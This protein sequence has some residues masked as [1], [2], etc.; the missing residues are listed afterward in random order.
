MS[1]ILIKLKDNSTRFFLTTMSGYSIFRNEWTEVNDNDKEIQRIITYRNDIELKD[2]KMKEDDSKSDEIEN[3]DEI[4]EIVEEDD[5]EE[6]LSLEEFINSEIKKAEEEKGKPLTKKQ[7][8][9]IIN[10]I[11]KEQE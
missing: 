2:I 3:S 11:K 10:K 5:T 6:E 4:E 7:K 9:K 1:K 8:E